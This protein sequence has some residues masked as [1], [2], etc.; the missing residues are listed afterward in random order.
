M[1]R[2]PL[3]PMYAKEAKQHGTCQGKLLD[4]YRKVGREGITVWSNVVIQFCVW[5]QRNTSFKGKPPIP[6]TEGRTWGNPTEPKPQTLL[7]L[8]PLSFYNIG[9]V[10]ARYSPKII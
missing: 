3:K 4:C 10:S 8:L 1:R 6:A 2:K 5:Q 7:S 9:T